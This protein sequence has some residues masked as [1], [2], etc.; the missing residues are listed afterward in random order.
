MVYLNITPKQLKLGIFNF[1]QI[2]LLYIPKP[3]ELKKI[4]RLVYQVRQCL[5]GVPRQ[6]ILPKCLNWEGLLPTGILNIYLAEFQKFQKK[7]IYIFMFMNCFCSTKQRFASL[8][9]VVQ[10]TNYIQFFYSTHNTLPRDHQDHQRMIV[11]LTFMIVKNLRLFLTVVT[12]TRQIVNDD[13]CVFVNLS[14]CVFV[15]LCT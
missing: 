5:M 11:D 15:Y 1:Y 6:W 10:C 8:L 9:N 7:K 3:I 12:P 14:T 13:S 2:L 4:T